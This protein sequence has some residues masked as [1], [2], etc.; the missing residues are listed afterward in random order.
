M[1]AAVAIGLVRVMGTEAQEVEYQKVCCYCCCCCISDFVGGRGYSFGLDREISVVGAE[2]VL[3]YLLVSAVCLEL[4]M[5]LDWSSRMI[6]PCL[7][8]DA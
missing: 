1:I 2:V 4:M 7:R 5:M 6:Q 8:V 3:L